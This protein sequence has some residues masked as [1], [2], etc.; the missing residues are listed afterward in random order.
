MRGKAGKIPII[1]STVYWVGL[2]ENF[3]TTKKMA[4]TGKKMSFWRVFG[5]EVTSQIC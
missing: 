1:V 5:R 3:Q 4:F 2:N